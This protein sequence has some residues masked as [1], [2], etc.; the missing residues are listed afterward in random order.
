MIFRSD[1]VDRQMRR[2]GGRK[3]KERRTIVLTAG[4]LTKTCLVP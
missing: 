4:D 1:C 2:D 3:G